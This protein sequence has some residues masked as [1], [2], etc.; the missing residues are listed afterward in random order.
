LQGGS[1]LTVGLLSHLI[2]RGAL[3]RKAPELSPVKRSGAAASA[4]AAVP[5]PQ[6]AAAS[7]AAL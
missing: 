2:G 1:T 6:P 7:D 3:H 4:P 5:N